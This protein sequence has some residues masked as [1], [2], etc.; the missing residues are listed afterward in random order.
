MKTIKVGTLS[1]VADSD[2]RTIGEV[3]WDEPEECDKKYPEKLPSEPGVYIPGKSSPGKS[4]PETIEF[5]VLCD[6]HTFELLKKL[7]GKVA[8]YKI[9]FHYK[10]PIEKRMVARMILLD[11]WDFDG[12]I[13]VRLFLEAVGE[14]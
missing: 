12:G 7:D 1:V 6:S 13:S 10:N 2:E 9:C 5:S 3:L 4:S 14:S 11:F 8:E